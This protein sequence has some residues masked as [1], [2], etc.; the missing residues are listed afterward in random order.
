MTIISLFLTLIYIGY[1]I[2]NKGI[3]HSLSATYYDNGASFSI[4]LFLATIL[5]IPKVMLITPENF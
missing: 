4:I 1:C 3:P 2:V 5:L